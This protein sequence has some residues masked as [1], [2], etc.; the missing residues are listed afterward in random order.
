MQHVR[1]WFGC[2]GEGRVG[3]GPCGQRTKSPNVN[4]SQDLAGSLGSEKAKSG[5]IHN[6]GGQ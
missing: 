4:P 5:P 6:L 1:V 2:S 3:W